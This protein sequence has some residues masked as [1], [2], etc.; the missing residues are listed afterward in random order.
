MSKAH[1]PARHYEGQGI[2]DS[3]HHS[4]LPCLRL[5]KVHAFLAGASTEGLLIPLKPAITTTPST[6]GGC[7]VFHTAATTYASQGA[8]KGNWAFGYEKQRSSIWA[9]FAP[10][11][12]C[13][14]DCSHIT[15]RQASPL[16]ALCEL[17]NPLHV[18]L[19]ASHYDSSF[20]LLFDCVRCESRR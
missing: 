11:R 10:S 15:P 8:W 9:T 16:K 19:T 18:L 2:L 3:Y 17:P 20:T 14:D 13:E 7:S 12:P 5:G 1:G 4:A 6:P